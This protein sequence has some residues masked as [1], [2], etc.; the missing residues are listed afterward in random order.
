MYRYS[1]SLRYWFFTFLLWA[2]IVFAIFSTI[3]SFLF[4]PDVPLV[5][6]IFMA[7]FCAFFFYIV[8]SIT[9][10]F[11]LSVEINK[12]AIYLFSGFR[13]QKLT[14]ITNIVLINTPMTQ[15]IIMQE[16]LFGKLGAHLLIEHS[17][18]STVVEHVSNFSKYEN[19]LSELEKITGKRIRTAG[20]PL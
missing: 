10:K 17:G 4:S 13:R 18:G 5:V 16:M 20:S 12:E 14:G 11:V 8:Y 19:L 15:R 3:W 6:D 7:I 9:F 1:R 2:I